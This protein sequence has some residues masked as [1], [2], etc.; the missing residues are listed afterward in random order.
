MAS[1]LAVV[2][3]AAMNVVYTFLFQTLLSYLEDLSETLTSSGCIPRNGIIGSYS[4]SIFKF[5]RNGHTIFHRGGTI[6]NSH[7]LCP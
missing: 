6:S 5:V 2:Y 7:L 1:T 3:N 4:N